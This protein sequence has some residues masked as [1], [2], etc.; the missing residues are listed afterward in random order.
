MYEGVGLSF[1]RAGKEDV[2]PFANT[3]TSK[4]EVCFSVDSCWFDFPGPLQ[5]CASVALDQ[6]GLHMGPHGLSPRELAP[7][8]CKDLPSE[9]TWL[10]ERKFIEFLSSSSEIS[11]AL[12]L[13]SGSQ[14]SITRQKL[15]GAAARHE[16]YV[17]TGGLSG[18]IWHGD[19]AFVAENEAEEVVTQPG[20]LKDVSTCGDIM[21]SLANS[22]DALVAL[23]RAVLHFEQQWE[24]DQL[25]RENARS[26]LVQLV[27]E[28]RNIAE[29]VMG[30]GTDNL[31]YV[32]EPVKG[33]KR[34]IERNSKNLVKYVGA[35]VSQFGLA[36]DNDT[37]KE[38]APV[39]A[40]TPATPFP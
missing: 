19:R 7:D 12:L 31:G 24:N 17:P 34:D 36:S 30:I 28:A 37:G 5:H 2:P 1:G 16:R 18:A 6:P 14:G 4:D 40:H 29:I 38:V 33:L 27:D 10:H 8:I 3:C 21:R 35:L 15:E 13:G 23:E 39:A 32:G 25:E 26:W 11:L 20:K 22:R 9:L